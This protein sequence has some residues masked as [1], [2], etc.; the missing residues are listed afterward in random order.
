MCACVRARVCAM[1]YVAVRACA[2]GA[3]E[4]GAR[5]VCACVV[6]LWYACVCA[7]ICVCVCI[8]V[9]ARVSTRVCAH[10]CTCMCV[11][12]ASRHV[13][14]ACMMRGECVCVRCVRVACVCGACMRAY[15]LSL[16]LR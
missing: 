3:F 15:V 13:Y 1:W 2:C 14:G 11:C 5:V 6:R 10:T 8:Q 12:D 9:R 16:T 4:C 7:C